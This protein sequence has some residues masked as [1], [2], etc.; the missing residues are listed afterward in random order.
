MSKTLNFTLG[1]N[2][3][4]VLLEIADEKLIN[5]DYRNAIETLTKSL[6]GMKDGLA[7]EILRRKKFIGVE[8][9]TQQI[10]MS[11]KKDIENV[12]VGHISDP[13]K[14]ID[15]RLSQL[16]SKGNDLTSDQTRMSIDKTLSSVYF[17]E[18]DHGDVIDII[19]NYNS[20]KFVDKFRKLVLSDEKVSLIYYMLLEMKEWMEDYVKLQQLNHFFFTTKLKSTT[21][22][23]IK[24][25]IVELT[26]TIYNNS[27]VVIDSKFKELDNYLSA[28]KSIDEKVSDGIQPN[29]KG[30][31]NDAGWISPDG[32]YYGLDGE[33][34]NMLH[35]QIQDS[36]IEQGIVTEDKDCYKGGWLK[37]HKNWFLYDGFYH[38]VDL[39]QAQKEVMEDIV[40]NKHAC[41]VK[42]G[43]EQTPLS[44]SML[45]MIEP[46]QFKLKF[47]KV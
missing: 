29:E 20:D 16:K 24:D 36:L 14:Y 7:I 47:F 12:G 44:L 42:L 27:S 4:N 43:L 5:A 33:I 11:D 19:E 23:F 18:V 32:V 46:I 40:E 10:L 37:Q 6:I 25:E 30:I 39:T 22:D 17:L 3:A 9:E 41:S 15:F 13:K 1:D 2:L 31:Y 8:M 28:I 34:A 35:N 38:G 21:L 26:S 45:K